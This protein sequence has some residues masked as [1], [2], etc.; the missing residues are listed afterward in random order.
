MAQKQLFLLWNS[1]CLQN[2]LKNK[3]IKPI[4]IPR[5]T[6]PPLPCSSY[7]H[8]WSLACVFLQA[9]PQLLI[10]PGWGP[11]SSLG[12]KRWDCDVHFTARPGWAVWLLPGV[13]WSW[14]RRKELRERCWSA[15]SRNRLLVRQTALRDTHESGKCPVHMPPPTR[16]KKKE[17]GIFRFKLP[18]GKITHFGSVWC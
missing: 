8:C 12:C 4:L 1:M 7:G 15:C 6:P 5:P 14:W 16:K 2:K 10:S 3:H 9:R 18:K 11:S 17:H 13:C